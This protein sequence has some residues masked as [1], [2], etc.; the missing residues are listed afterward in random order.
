MRYLPMSFDTKNKTALIIGGDH[1]ALSKIKDLL[2]SEF[3]IYVISEQFIDEII[4][5]SN[6]NSERIFLKQGR[7]DGSFVF[8]GYDYL[9]IATHNFDLNQALEE[10][11]KKS[12]IPYQR[13]DVLSSSNLLMNK[14]ISKEGLTI[15]ISTNGLNPAI[16]EIVYDDIN[17][18]LSD[19]NEEKI[20]ILNEIRRQLIRRNA[21]NI[22]DTIKD[23]YYQEKFT[24]NKYLD[25]L[26]NDEQYN[27]EVKEIKEE[28]NSKIKDIKKD[29]ESDH[30]SDTINNKEGGK[31]KNE[32]RKIKNEINDTFESGKITLEEKLA[33]KRKKEEL[34]NLEKDEKMQKETDEAFD[35]YDK[36]D[37]EETANRKIKNEKEEH[38]KN[39]FEK[40]ISE[41][42][43]EIKDKLEKMKS[44]HKE[45]E[46]E[47][48]EKYNNNKEGLEMKLDYS[49]EHSKAKHEEHKEEFKE[50]LNAEKNKLK[51]EEKEIKDEILAGKEHIKGE[52]SKLKEDFKDIDNKVVDPSKE[53]QVELSED[54]KN[55]YKNMENKVADPV[56]G[57]REDLKDTK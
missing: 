52:A 6:A 12:N 18:L 14:V 26:E 5:L 40:A 31:M 42:K 15:G 20:L 53:M 43:K 21:L 35:R 33:D 46:I 55:D 51:Y 44:E 38:A 11:A 27:K 24:I 36:L 48:K 3:K 28:L 29:Y 34:L 56:E 41:D 22:D 23:L 32:F 49:K 7:I 30:K 16:S 10:R 8:F 9:V 4:K 19:Y 39:K 1:I 2:Q 37:A 25:K 13:C 57:F 50:K 17:N 45:D 47:R 54:I